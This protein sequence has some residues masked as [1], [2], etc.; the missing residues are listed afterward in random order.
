MA[1]CQRIENMSF[2]VNEDGILAS[3]SKLLSESQTGKSDTPH[4]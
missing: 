1:V 2:I 4:L 3:K